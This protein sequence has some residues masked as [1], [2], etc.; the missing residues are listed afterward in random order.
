[1][2]CKKCFL[3]SVSLVLWNRAWLMFKVPHDWNN[4]E[5][6]LTFW[7][8]TTSCWFT[9]NQKPGRGVNSIHHSDFCSSHPTCSIKEQ[10]GLA[11]TALPAW[12]PSLASV[13]SGAPLT[14]PARTDAARAGLQ[15]PARRGAKPR[16]PHSSNFWKKTANRTAERQGNP[17]LYITF[18]CTISVPLRSLQA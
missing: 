17:E 15:H 10:A 8:S 2:S 6:N 14:P 9:I 4:T 5:T 18:V 12:H 1:M 3:P 11:F 7:N 16:T 13:G